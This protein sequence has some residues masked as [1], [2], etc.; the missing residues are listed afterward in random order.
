MKNITLIISTVIMS[1]LF[2][3]AQGPYSLPFQETFSTLS[4]GVAYT[5]ETLNATLATKGWGYP[6]PKSVTGP[7]TVRVHTKSI[8]EGG[9]ILTPEINVPSGTALELNF[10]MRAFLNDIGGGDV[11]TKRCC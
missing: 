4:L 3:K 6:V 5:E 10:V 7:T 1:A 2:V 8:S 9:Y 11:P